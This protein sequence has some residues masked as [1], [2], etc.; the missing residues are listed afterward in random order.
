MENFLCAWYYTRLFFN[1]K[2]FTSFSSQSTS[3]NKCYSSYCTDME[4]RFKKGKTRTGSRSIWF[5]LCCAIISLESARSLQSPA[6]SPRKGPLSSGSI[7]RDFSLG[8][9]LL[10][11]SVCDRLSPRRA[12]PRAG[13]GV[14]GLG[15]QHAAVYSIHALWGLDG[16]VEATWGV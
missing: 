4:L 8:L 10:P 11:A 1:F 9:A 5:H 15:R 16:K 7:A 14:T 13:P 3:Q 12:P 2:Y 6:P